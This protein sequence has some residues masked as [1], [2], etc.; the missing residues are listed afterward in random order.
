M[1]RRA[2]AAFLFPLLGGSFHSS[3]TRPHFVLVGHRPCLSRSLHH[4]LPPKASPSLLRLYSFSD[5]AVEEVRRAVSLVDVVGQYLELKQKGD[6]EWLGLCPFHED[7]NPSMFVNDQK[8]VFNC[9]SCRASGDVFKFVM[10]SEGLSFAQAVQVLADQAGVVLPDDGALGP[11][12][13]HS[14]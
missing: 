4:P 12:R 11:R 6:G 5:E 14:R 10:E 9:F 13:N 8:G 7:N 3:I 2:W 1:L